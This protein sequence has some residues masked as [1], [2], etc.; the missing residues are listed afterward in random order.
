MM[1]LVSRCPFCEDC[2]VMFDDASLEAWFATP[3]SD[4]REPCQHLACA[5]ISLSGYP[6]SAKCGPSTE[7]C[8]D[9]LWIQGEGWVSFASR[10]KHAMAQYLDELWCEPRTQ[11]DCAPQTPYRFVGG[12]ALA[13]EEEC[14]GSGQ[15]T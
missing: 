14:P 4:R 13:R 9:W 2:C 15:V 10:E 7:V 3:R 12:T 5:S 1:H 8:R 11:R 6:A